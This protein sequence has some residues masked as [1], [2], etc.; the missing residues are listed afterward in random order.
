MNEESRHRLR[1]CICNEDYLIERV[2]SRCSYTCSKR[3][4]NKK[5]ILKKAG[6]PVP[7]PE[8][9]GVLAPESGEG[10]GRQ[11]A[12]DQDNRRYRDLAGRF[13]ASVI[14][15]CENRVLPP[16]LEIKLD[17][18]DGIC[19]DMDERGV[20]PTAMWTQLR[21]LID[22]LVKQMNHLI[23]DA[24]KAEQAPAKGGA[25]HQKWSH[26]ALLAVR[27]EL[28]MPTWADEPEAA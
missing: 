7:F 13:R 18:I 2:V 21:G 28:E 9:V 26:D 16:S 6:R 25:G 10:V 23:E 3:C 12:G 1:C 8:N 5:Y 24:R 27:G 20:A 17:A 22:L 15:G 11:E 4:R 19:L 14:G